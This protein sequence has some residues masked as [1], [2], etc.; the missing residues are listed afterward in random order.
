MFA[1]VLVVV[2]VLAERAA[3][4][5]MVQGLTPVDARVELGLDR[6]SFFLGENVLIHYCVRNVSLFPMKI[7]IGG[8]Y[9]GS[10]RSLRFEFAVTNERGDLM[11]DPDPSGFGLGGLGGTPVIAAGERW[12]QSLPLA[13]Y[14]RIDEPGAYSISVT[15][16]L[17]WPPGTAPV[18]RADV[19]LVQ[20]T[21]DEAEAVVAA[22]E[23]LPP[24]AGVNMT[25]RLDDPYA[26]FSALRYGVF[27]EPLARRVAGGSVAAVSGV[28]AIPTPE[29]TLLLIEL[30]RHSDPD[31]SRASARQLSTR[32]PEPAPETGLPRR[33][34]LAD[35]PRDPRRYLRDRSW[36]MDF[37]PDVR[38]AARRLLGFEDLDSMIAGA[39]LAQSVG[40]P[41]D[42]AALAAALDALIAQTVAGAFDPKSYP[43]PRDAAQELLHAAQ[44]LLARGHP[45]PLLAV[46]PADAMFI[47]KAV[48]QGRQPDGWR[49][50]IVRALAHDVPFV[51][52]F[53][54]RAIPSGEADYF[55]AGLRGSFDVGDI[56]VRSAACRL[57]GRE[58]LTALKDQVVGIVRLEKNWLLLDSAVDAVR[59]LGTL[60]EALEPLTYRLAEKDMVFDVLTR[61]TQVFE[62]HGVSSENVAYDLKLGAE[63]GIRW[64]SFISG[65][66]AD[67]DAGRRIS[68]DE[69]DLPMDLLPPGYRLDRRGKPDW[70]PRR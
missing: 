33:N 16:D 29:A 64:R 50:V 41:G 62:P 58:R 44:A 49:D 30:L 6:P 56:D 14:A 32:L 27:L 39:L 28:G 15:H 38:A 9:R 13:R 18:G 66:R 36:R 31:V 37:V 57:V 54:I 10:S 43:Q 11:P 40:Q 8:D 55:M 59:Q 25:G 21:P 63:L 1:G 35:D 24:R 48:E 12:C 2:A 26:D 51:R 61:L 19:R 20:P 23:Q 60:S 69:P 42:A 53:G 45:L 7:A 3:P 34:P 52:E 67:V 70:P 46:T 4:V 17:G 65:R 47:L 22:M 68:L 5:T